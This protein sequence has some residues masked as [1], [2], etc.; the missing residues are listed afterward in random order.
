MYRHNNLSGKRFGRL[1]V[2]ER[3]GTAKDRHIVWKCACDC[4][5]F[6]DVIGRDLKSGHTK[7]C[8]CIQIDVSTIHGGRSTENTER[9]YFVWRGIIARCKTPTASGYEYYGARGI[10]VCEQW[11]KYEAFRDWAYKNGYDE[12]APRYKCTIDRID[13]DGDYCPENCRWVDMSVQNSNKRAK[14]DG[15]KVDGCL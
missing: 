13:C 7:S 8:G 4:G 15:G 10:S 12:N 5:K 11:M 3:R 2:L 14:M 9:L 1:T 6:V